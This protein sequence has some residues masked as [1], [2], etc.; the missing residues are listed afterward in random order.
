MVQDSRPSSELVRQLLTTLPLGDF[1]TP[2]QLSSQI[3]R[4]VPW[5]LQAIEAGELPARRVRGE[6]LISKDALNEYFRRS[7][8]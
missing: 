8:S 5:V 4:P 2:Q 3:G 6:W 7:Q 1:F